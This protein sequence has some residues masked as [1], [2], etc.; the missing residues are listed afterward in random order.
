M[1]TFSCTRNIHRLCK[2][3]AKN[4]KD[5]SGG[6]AFGR[7]MVGTSAILMA[8]DYDEERRKD[9][10]GVYEVRTHGGTIIDAKNTFPFSTFLVAGRI[11]NAEEKR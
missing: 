2:R 6:E 9:G 8:A 5:F 10:L 7:M 11:F 3:I 1:V 4:E